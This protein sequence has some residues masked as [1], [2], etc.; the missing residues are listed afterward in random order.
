M[1]GLLSALGC[2]VV[3]TPAS[4]PTDS[5]QKNGGSELARRTAADVG[6]SAT[7]SCSGKV[8]AAAR[9]RSGLLSTFWRALAP[10][11]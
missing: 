3:G 11:G 2:G 8:R 10:T 9:G 1:S 7:S 6:P 4:E 5:R